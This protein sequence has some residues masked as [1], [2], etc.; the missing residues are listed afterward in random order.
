MRS[1]DVGLGRHG[2]ASFAHQA[3][4]SQSSGVIVFP[5]TSG[6]KGAIERLDGCGVIGFKSPPVLPGSVQNFKDQA[7]ATTFGGKQ[8]R[9]LDASR[10]Q[11]QARGR[12]RGRRREVDR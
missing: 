11:E 2:R 1:H 6:R 10:S 9:Y 8:A 3:P 5:S 7:K 4:Q 12:S